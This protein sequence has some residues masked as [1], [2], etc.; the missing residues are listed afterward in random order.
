MGAARMRALS[1]LSWLLPQTTLAPLDKVS[2]T[3]PA[4]VVLP[5]LT[6]AKVSDTRE[7]TIWVTTVTYLVE[8]PCGPDACAAG[9]GMIFTRPEGDS[10]TR[11]GI[12]ASL[13]RTWWSSESCMVVTGTR[14][15]RCTR[16]PWGQTLVTCARHTWTSL[17]LIWAES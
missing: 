10:V 6:W 17:S 13:P 7:P 2:M 12:T 5:L 11:P 9:S 1:V 15:A 4:S 16:S 8:I 3:C 14:I